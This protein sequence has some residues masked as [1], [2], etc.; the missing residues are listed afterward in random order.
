MRLA[1]N[2]AGRHR[3]TGVGGGGRAL[4]TDLAIGEARVRLQLCPGCNRPLPAGTRRCPACGMRFLADVQL[5]RAMVLLVAGFAIGLLAGGSVVTAGVMAG[6]PKLVAAD[7]RPADER[8]ANTNQANPATPPP[9]A[10]PAPASPLVPTNPAT[11]PAVARSAL[12]QIATANER[13]AVGQAALHDALAATNFDPAAA[14]DAI[15]LV[16][17]EATAGADQL[18]RLATWS[19][20]T[21][22]AGDLRAFYD[23]LRSVARAGL[24]NSMTNGPA[25]R[26]T[27]EALQSSLARLPELDARLGILLAL[28]GLATPTP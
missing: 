24:A 10:T 21:T 20:A 18:A 1:L 25:Y 19:R 3:A 8:L 4:E 5:R 6:L 14:A 2:L 28:A 15:R 16:A 22:L 11:V 13:L 26:A 9:E 7:A 27:V 23:D 12:R 17:V